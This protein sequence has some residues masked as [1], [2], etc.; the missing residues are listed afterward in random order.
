MHTLQPRRHIV[1]R[2]AWRGR[3]RHPSPPMMSVMEAVPFHFPLVFG[4]AECRAAGYPERQVSRVVAGG[5]WTRLRHGQFLRGCR[6]RPRPAMAG[7]GVGDGAFPPTR[8]Q[9][10]ACRSRLAPAGSAGRL[11]PDDVHLHARV[12]TRRRESGHPSGS[13]RRRRDR[14]H[15]AGA[16]HQRCQDRHRLR[17]IHARPGRARDRGSRAPRWSPDL[18]GVAAGGRAL[19]GLAGRRPGTKGRRPRGRS[20]RDAAG[21]LVGVV[22]RGERCAG[23]SEAGRRVRPRRLPWATRRLVAARGGRRG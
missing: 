16:S 8:P 11:G 17:S 4:R 23:T 9:P 14:R 1:H 21:I 22:V 10:R 12:P 5:R 6:P 18:P 2:A 3:D 7:R 15:G 19:P 20:A 13:S